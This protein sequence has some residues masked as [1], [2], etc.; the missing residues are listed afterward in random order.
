MCINQLQ[1]VKLSAMN[2]FL[3]TSYAKI[4]SSRMLYLIKKCDPF[5]KIY[6]LSKQDSSD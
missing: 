6:I 5:L 2:H 1:L 4:H 3:W